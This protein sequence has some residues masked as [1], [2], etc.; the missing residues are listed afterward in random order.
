[1][2]QNTI[3]EICEASERL[4][5]KLN[6]EKYKNLSGLK[7]VSD[8]EEIF[9]KYPDFRDP[10]TF[11][12]I[13]PI[14][15]CEETEK[16][17][18]RLII[19]FLAKT[20]LEGR[21]AKLRDRILNAECGALI[22]YDKK[23]IHYRSVLDTIKN[24]PNK[25]IRKELDEKR[26][27][28]VSRLNP[29]YLKLFEAY[30]RDAAELGYPT[31]M[32]LCDDTDCL[33]LSKL[34]EEARLFLSDSDYIYRDLLKWFLL[35]RM[36]LRL[37]GLSLNDLHYLFSSYEL[38]ANFPESL[39]VSIAKRLFSDMG[40]EFTG[41]LKIDS[42]KRGGK[43]S[44]SFCSPLEVPNRIL[45]SISPSEGVANYESFFQTLGKALYYAHTEPG[46]PFEFR[47][48]A[49]PTYLEIFSHLFKN[50]IYQPKWIKRYLK[51]DPGK[52]FLEFLY[53]RRLNGLRY[54]CGK[55]IYEFLIHGDGEYKDKSEHYS[56]T[57]KEATLAN[58]DK[59]DYLIDIEPFFY[60]AVYL[61]ASLIEVSFRA[62][63][64]EAFDEEWWR[65]KE[66]GYF[67]L[68]LWKDGGRITSKDIAEKSGVKRIDSTSLII[69]FQDALRL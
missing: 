18:L 58:H 49:E 23:S 8:Q 54:Y 46:G 21:S 12:S 24:E 10:G 68:N 40:I 43:I 2:D 15:A 11:R 28:V 6:L 38:R 33:Q 44:G 69:D 57:L 48:L 50:L 64:R 26:R 30:N 39:T 36:E 47:I 22:T 60:T 13:K 29:L 35:N 62:F 63:L 20:L 14:Q 52:D 1:M 17:G 61:N 34:T 59:A 25:S 31:Y 19:S 16:I 27:Q 45:C 7:S 4:L 53:L 41:G 3:T 32:K 55:L 65:K 37:E 42:E 66:A 56:Q 67:L 9:R 51:H 5:K